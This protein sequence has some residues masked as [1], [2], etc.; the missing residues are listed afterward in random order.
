ML[1]ATPQVLEHTAQAAPVS[2]DAMLAAHVPMDGT[3][4]EDARQAPLIPGNA[5]TAA[6][7]PESDKKAS[8]VPEAVEKTYPVPEAT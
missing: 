3:Q 1:V 2:K 7:A 6:S 4:T 5:R 8:P